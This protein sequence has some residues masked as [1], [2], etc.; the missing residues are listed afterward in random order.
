M[1]NRFKQ[2]LAGVSE[3]IDDF[4]LEGEELI[5][6]LK[7][8][9]VYNKLLGGYG[10]LLSALDQTIFCLPV[11]NEYT[12]L[13][14]GCGGADTMKRV[15]EISTKRGYKLK[16]KGIDANPFIVEYAKKQTANFTEIE[17]KIKIY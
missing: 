15:A 17:I 3:I 10:A 6:N 16:M 11:G 7:E 2:R 9:E 5:T 13:D 14:V 12:L 4:S 8:I 1:F